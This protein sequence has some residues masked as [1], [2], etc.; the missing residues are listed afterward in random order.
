MTPA[1]PRRPFTLLDAMLL[2]AATAVGFVAFR[3]YWPLYFRYNSV[4]SQDRAFNLIV[5]C[6][7]FLAL[8]WMICVLGLRLKGPRP[9]ARLLAREPGVVACAAA[10]VAATL[11]GLKI[12][13]W[14][15]FRP[16]RS[17][18]DGLWPWDQAWYMIMEYVYP[19]VAFAWLT[20]AI[21]GRWR[22]D[23]GWQD[24]LGRVL[25]AYF[26]AE[27]LLIDLKPWLIGSFPIL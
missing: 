18:A 16:W 9:R 13:L 24:R 5:H 20:L 21:S 3:D 1:R 15:A 2:T 14:M 12:A 4:A 10:L 25:G 27:Y 22:A 11:G 6:P 23:P 26:V 19:S 7:A 8:P 17:R